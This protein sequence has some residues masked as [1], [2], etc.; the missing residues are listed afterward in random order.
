[1]N[2]EMVKRYDRGRRLIKEL[3]GVVDNYQKL[4]FYLGTSEFEEDSRDLLYDQ[5][6]AMKSYIDVLIQRIAEVDY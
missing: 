2:Q 4:Q 6:F 1:M 5:S 3:E